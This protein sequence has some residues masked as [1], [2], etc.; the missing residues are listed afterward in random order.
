MLLQITGHSTL[1][2]ETSIWAAVSTSE[3]EGRQAGALGLKH[4]WDSTVSMWCP[5][6]PATSVPP[7][8]WGTFI[9]HP[10]YQGH[11][12]PAQEQYAEAPG[13]RV[14]APPGHEESKGII[15]HS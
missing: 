3:K 15:Q 5:L 1:P 7:A 14:G 12:T 13:E 9:S 2:E 10:Y 6:S 8:A 4:H 11:K